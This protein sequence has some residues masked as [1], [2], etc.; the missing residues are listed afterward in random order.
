MIRVSCAAL[1]RI[2]HSD[3]RFL[4]GL[5]RNRLRHG[6]RVLTPY[7]GAST[8]DDSTVLRGLGVRF[9]RDDVK[10]LRFLIEE[11]RIAEFEAWFRSRSG[12]ESDPLRELAEELVTE[13]NLLPQ[14]D[15]DT[16][17][18]DY[19]GLVMTEAETSRGAVRGRLT[20][21]YLE[22]FDVGLPDRLWR[23]LD[24]RLSKLDS[25][26]RLVTV[27]E[28][29]AGQGPDG[30]AIASTAAFLLRPGGSTSGMTS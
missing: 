4:V 24:G 11:D 23:Q 8:F 19:L 18:V 29:E 13:E 26:A 30:I 21:Y 14:F 1:C 25:T 22:I 17:T 3:G 28:I 6:E 20:R 16:L 7:G 12:R 15:P 10:D 9:E 2:R 27:D 5:N